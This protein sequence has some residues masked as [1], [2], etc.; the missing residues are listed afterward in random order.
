M[1]RPQRATGPNDLVDWSVLHDR[2]YDLAPEWQVPRPDVAGLRTPEEI[3]W[4]R[5]CLRAGHPFRS[6][7]NAPQLRT[8]RGQRLASRMPFAGATAAATAWLTGNGWG[9]AALIIVPAIALSMIANL[10]SV[11]FWLAM[12]AI[13]AIP[14]TDKIN[15]DAVAKESLRPVAIAYK[16]RPEEMQIVRDVRTAMRQV[17]GSRASREGYLVQHQVLVD[18]NATADALTRRVVEMS[19]VR[20]QINALSG[21]VRQHAE[22]A[23][24]QVTASMQA[25]VQAL[26]SYAGHVRQLDRYLHEVDSTIAAGP[27]FESIRGL[28]A[29]SVED[30]QQVPRLIDASSLTQ[31]ASAAIAATA[32]EAAGDLYRLLGT[33][34]PSLPRLR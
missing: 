33:T 34:T 28:L 1:S 12:L 32:N 20:S 15:R 5:A 11:A 4:L 22:E 8:D 24:G 14:V 7:V 26:Q 17:T 3:E 27:V 21:P 25:Q 16:L 30:E 31:S 18:L 2:V 6:D 13:V 23:M 29:S 9:I 19:R 10:G